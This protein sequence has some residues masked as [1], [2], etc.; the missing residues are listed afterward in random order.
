MTAITLPLLCTKATAENYRSDLIGLPASQLPGIIGIA[1]DKHENDLTDM[2]I[3]YYKD[4]KVL[5]EK[6]SVISVR[7]KQL[8]TPQ[9]KK[10]PVEAPV[11]AKVEAIS[12]PEVDTETFEDIL[13]ELE[14]KS[15]KVDEDK[16]NKKQKGIN[17]LKSLIKK[18]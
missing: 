13:G 2:K 14:K 3:W 16:G 11:E 7:A 5:I 6:D 10:A 15:A 9:K 18:R 1:M 4:F 17:K 12:L 8:A